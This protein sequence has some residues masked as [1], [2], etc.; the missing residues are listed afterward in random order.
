MTNKSA[1][2]YMNILGDSIIQSLK[3]E[4]KHEK[5]PRSYVEAGKFADLFLVFPA[6]L[7]TCQQAL[8]RIPSLNVPEMRPLGTF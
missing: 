7:E 6:I 4:K 8:I 2:I 3:S 1:R 5:W